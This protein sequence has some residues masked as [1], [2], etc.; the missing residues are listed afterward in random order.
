MR[1]LTYSMDKVRKYFN[2]T[3]D[4]HVY[5]IML[6]V[7]V[8]TAYPFW[9]VLV[10]SLSDPSKLTT[11]FLF[12]PRGFTLEAYIS[13][14][15][16]PNVINA[17][18]ISVARSVTAPVLSV[19]VSMLV[20]YSLSRRKLPGNKI[21]TWIFVMTMY[22]QI[23]LIPRYMV[24][25]T[26][27]LIGSFWVY[28]LPKMMNVFGMILMR[29]YIESLPEVLH[30]SAYVDGANEFV[31]FSRITVPLCKPVMAAVGLLT[32]VNN[33]NNYTDTLIFNSLKKELY[34]LQYVLIQFV[35]SMSS[36]S[37]TMEEM[38]AMADRI[39]LTPMVVRMAITIV[40]VV[41]ISLVYPYLQRYFIKGIMIGAVKG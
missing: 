21:L 17:F 10:Y 36:R 7:F 6:I 30:D 3:L 13:V 34:T 35:Q 41:P 14:F 5:A 1:I 8:V 29:A 18:F 33:W 12:L 25:K 22:V 24:I 15:K 28:I 32:C 2:F 26:L 11:S 9:Y 23:G 40:C 31:I 20:A 19:M 37:A 27:G 39:A 16:S 38:S 4:F